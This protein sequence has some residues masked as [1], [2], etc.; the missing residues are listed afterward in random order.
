MTVQV[1]AQF[2]SKVMLFWIK[3]Q[4]TFLLVHKQLNSRQSTPAIGVEDT[5]APAVIS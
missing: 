5:L 2:P 1:F 3:R 4:A